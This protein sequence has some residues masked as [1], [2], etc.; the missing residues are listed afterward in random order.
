MMILPAD[1]DDDLSLSAMADH[2]KLETMSIK[3]QKKLRLGVGAE[4]SVLTRYLH[5]RKIVRTAIVNIAAN[6]I[7]KGLKVKH[8]GSRR[9]NGRDAVVVYLTTD[10]VNDSNTDLYAFK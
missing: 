5:P 7:T 3:R 9:S 1:S 2:H 6:D 10:L 4:V 8:L